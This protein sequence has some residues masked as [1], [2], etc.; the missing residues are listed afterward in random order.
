MHTKFLAW[1]TER[2]I[3][4]PLTLLGSPQDPSYRYLAAPADS[5]LAPGSTIVRAP[6][7]ACL[8]DDSLEGLA[9]RVAREK[10]LGTT[11][12]YAPYLDI[13]PELDSPSVKAMPRFWAAERLGSVT[14][15]GQLEAR[16]REDER[17]RVDPW[18]VQ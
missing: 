1:C 10:S 3:S 12:E 18:L 17:P 11:S 14:D 9:E 4:T 7:D 13:L 8:I 15:G 6:L 2:G 5:A 16:M